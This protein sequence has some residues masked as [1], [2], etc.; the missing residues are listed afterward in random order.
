MFLTKLL[1][2]ITNDFLIFFYFFFRRI[3]ILKK[4]R[5]FCPQKEIK[6]KLWLYFLAYSQ[7][8]FSSI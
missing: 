7:L 3:C 4:K 6:K 2:G 1:F 5:Y 8:R